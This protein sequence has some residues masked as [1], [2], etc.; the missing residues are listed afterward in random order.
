M[1][2]SP[3]GS[4]LFF[5][6]ER[7]VQFLETHGSMLAVVC[8]CGLRAR[9]PAQL[10]RDWAMVQNGDVDVANGGPVLPNTIINSSL[11]TLIGGSGCKV[12]EVAK[13][14][15]RVVDQRFQESTLTTSVTVST[16]TGESPRCQVESTRSCEL[17]HH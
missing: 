12:D 11:I 7:G 4:Y 8:R 2:N 15:E 17:S 5:T 1:R 13:L 3:I 10:S 6:W 16:L 14:V 9:S